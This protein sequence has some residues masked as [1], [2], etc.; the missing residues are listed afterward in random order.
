M[1]KLGMRLVPEMGHIHPADGM[2]L[3]VYAKGTQWR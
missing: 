3:L 2:P 1:M